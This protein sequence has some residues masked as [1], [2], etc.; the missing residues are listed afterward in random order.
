MTN[1]ELQRLA[2]KWLVRL[3]LSDWDVFIRFAKKGEDED[4]WGICFPSPTTREALIVIQN[5]CYFTEP[6]PD[7]YN[8][9][10]EV[11]LLHEI[12]HI[13]FAPFNHINNSM[14]GRVEEVI[15][16]HLSQ[17]LVALDRGDETLINPAAPRRLSR[18]ARFTKV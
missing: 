17:L 6:H 11:T 15:V 1:R 9:D 4:C 8:A 12:L 7:H 18:V 2:N 13:H 5:P 3:R 16:S 10:V 14:K